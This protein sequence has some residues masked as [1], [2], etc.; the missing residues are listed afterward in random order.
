MEAARYT[1]RLRPG[2]TAAAA[3]NAEWDRCRWVWNQCVG[4]DRDLWNE[5]G[6]TASGYGLSAELTDWRGR[7]EWLR[8]GSQNAQQNAVL[9]WAKAKQAF[10]K[11]KGQGRPKFK[12][13]HAASPTLEYSVNGFRLSDGRLIVA[14]G[15]SL[16]VVWHRELPSTPKTATVYR[17]AV[18]HWWVSFVVRRVAEQW[19]EV[20]G[21]VGIDWGVKV[22][23]TASD[24]A[25]D[26]PHAQHGQRASTRLAQAQRKMARRRRPK[27]QPTSKGYQAAR[28]ETAR[29][30]QKIAWQRKHDA[31]QWARRVVADNALIAVENFKPKFLARS[32]MARKSADAAIGQ[33]KR[34]LVD[35]GRRAGRTVVLVPP[36][37]TTMTCGE[38]AARAKQRL[39]LSERTFRCEACGHIADRDRNAARTIL[40]WA[41]IDPA[42]VESVRHDPPSGISAA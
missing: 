13:R 19:P 32:T 22:T 37:Y 10:F 9:S 3:L 23:A 1:Y 16:P 38:C 26:L 35:Y 21:R 8:D 5:E 31:R 33:A 7:N 11:V 14:G 18:G 39:P 25:Y 42:S 29:L 40:A 17:D 41:E 12:S 36:A 30:Y 28:R 34:E 27:G 15:I 24:P 6:I 20:T 2:K 4:R